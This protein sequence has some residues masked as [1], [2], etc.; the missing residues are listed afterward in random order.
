MRVLSAEL[1]VRADLH[2]HSNYSDGRDGISRILESALRR[3]I[4][5]LSITDHDTV[6]GSL[7]AMDV[8]DEEHLPLVV[9]PGI[10]V[11]A[12][13]GHILVYGLKGERFEK[14]MSVSEVVEIAADEGALTSIA[15]P[16][17]I[18]RH[19][20][21]KPSCFKAVDCIETFNAKSPPAFN[22]IS[23]VI[24][25]IYGKGQTAGSDAHRAEFVGYGYVELQVHDLEICSILNA[26]K[27]C[28]CRTGGSRRFL[29]P[30]R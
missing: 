2:I 28:L 24:R 10:E 16:L 26:L 30:N 6:Q 11:S 19:G 14:G 7:E 15:H 17:Q 13:E 5:V 3:G 18:F 22:A 9:I 12:A 27:N 21:F 23:R 25:R 4:K 29:M 20:A 8:V 1:P